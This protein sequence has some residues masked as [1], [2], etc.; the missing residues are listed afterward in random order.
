MTFRIFAEPSNGVVTHTAASKALASMP[1]LQ[2]LVAFLSHEMWPSASRLVDTMEKW[3]G[4][5]QPN[6]SG[7]ALAC[8]TD[9]PMFDVV[10]RDPERARRMAGAMTLMHTGP[11]YSVKHLLENFEWGEAARGVLVDV[12]GG[13]GTVGT[14]IARYLREMKCI[15][16][17]LHQV[18]EGVEVPEDLKVGRKIELYGA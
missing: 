16:Q 1:L 10:G 17:D 14:E 11:G 4:S 7:F 8:A 13:K 12:G 6:E 9:M 2:D 5:Q 18:V 3:P 15:V